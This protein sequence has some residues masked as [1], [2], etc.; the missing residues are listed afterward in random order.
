MMTT[1][2]LVLRYLNTVWRDGNISAV[3]ELADEDIVFTGF[4]EER[5][6]GRAQVKL[7][8]QMI[9]SLLGGFEFDVE[10]FVEDGDWFVA[11][12]RMSCV[13]RRTG[14]RHSTRLDVA[15]RFRGEVLVEARALIDF[16][17][18]FEKAGQLPPRTIDRLLLGE[19]AYFNPYGGAR[20][21]SGRVLAA[22]S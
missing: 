21:G 13:Y 16:V 10:L 7:Y 5:L 3:D 2:Q 17:G 11:M 15:G 8:Q 1:K 14:E 9:L 6:E 19:S 18:Y 12:L 22:L 4:E 20:T